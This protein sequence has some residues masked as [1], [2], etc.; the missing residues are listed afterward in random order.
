MGKLVKDMTEEE[1]ERKK[2]R[3]KI[4]GKKYR[5][6][7]KEKVKAKNRKYRETEAG[8]KSSRI[9]HWLNRG[10][11][12]PDYQDLYHYVYHECNHCETCKEEFIDNHNK[13]RRV[14]DHCHITYEIRGIICHSCNAKL[15]KQT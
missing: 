10:I 8:K 14:I 5:E 9:Q 3:E 4:S 11:V 7:N 12:Y 1:H 2:A 6:K 15:K 13:Y